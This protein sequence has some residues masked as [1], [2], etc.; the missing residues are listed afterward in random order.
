MRFNQAL[1]KK[2]IIIMMSTLAVATYWMP[3]Q[4]AMVTTESVAKNEQLSQRRQ[5]AADVLLK[6][7]VRE[8]L[9]AMAVNPTDVEKR[10]NSMTPQELSQLE[11]N[12]QNLPAGGSVLE[13]VVLVLLIFLILDIGGVTDVFPG[14]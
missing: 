14:V 12:I 11:A 6:D 4:A 10:I 1:K 5:H 8:Q 9:L 3:A 13:V 7:N 2:I